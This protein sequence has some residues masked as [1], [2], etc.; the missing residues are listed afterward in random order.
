MQA[1]DFGYAGSLAFLSVYPGKAMYSVDGSW[2]KHI[3]KHMPWFLIYCVK[4]TSSGKAKCLWQKRFECYRNTDPSGWNIVDFAG[5][6]YTSTI[7]YSANDVDPSSIYPTLK[8]EKDELKVTLEV[9]LYW[10]TGCGDANGNRV[11]T[12]H[13]AFGCYLV[14]PKS[15]TA[16]KGY[17]N[18]Y[19]TSVVIFT[20]NPGFPVSRP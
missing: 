8:I 7:T 11:N 5:N 18:L 9:H 15:A 19:F 1:S 2:N 10:Y 6:T 12:P 16:S 14:N 3:L 4:G 13:E 20:P 17:S